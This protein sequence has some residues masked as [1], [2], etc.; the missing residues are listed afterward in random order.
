[1]KK[2][3]LITSLSVIGVLASTAPI[4]INC[5]LTTKDVNTKVTYSDTITGLELP[6]KLFVESKYT[7]QMWAKT[8]TGMVIPNVKFKIEEETTASLNATISGNTVTFSPTM[9]TKG[10]KCTLEIGA[11]QN[12]IK[13][14]NST[15]TFSEV[16]YANNLL[17]LNGVEY[18]LADNINPNK[19]VTLNWA[20]NWISEFIPLKDGGTLYIDAG[21]GKSGYLWQKL[22]SLTLRSC[23]PRVGVIEDCF[24]AKCDALKEVKLLDGLSS[25]ITIED[26]FIE[27]AHNLETVDLSGFIDLD[28]IGGC[29]IDEARNL[30]YVRMPN[31]CAKDFKVDWNYSTEIPQTAIVDCGN[32]LASYQVTYPWSRWSGQMSGSEHNY[33]IKELKWSPYSNP[34]VNRTVTADLVLLDDNMTPL[35]PLAETW[36]IEPETDECLNA[37]YDYPGIVS[38]TPTEEAICRTTTLKVAVYNL[39]KKIAELT[40]KINVVNLT[41]TITYNGRTYDIAYAIKQDL[42]ITYTQEAWCKYVDQQIPLEF[43]DAVLNVGG[44]RSAWGNLTSLS[45]RSINPANTILKYYFL[46]SCVNLKTLDLSGLTHL[47]YIG[48]YFLYKCINLTS[49]ILPNMSPR[50]INVAYDYFLADVPSTTQFHCGQ[51]V[52]EYKHTLPWSTRASQ[53]VE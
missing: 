43:V 13:I 44:S 37:V 8:S 25:I 27:K 2:I 38:I 30:N 4:T 47:T 6:N 10:K 33:S 41:N 48:G 3:K 19:F 26:G 5:C 14:A 32:H 40:T 53:M 17:T 39:D 35:H 16:A 11:Y 52:E 21:Y 49:V 12:G 42:F 18:E 36:R 51:Y 24:L 23:D 34:I 7:S 1:M 9:E 46:D 15:T 45:L 50:S 28:R 20:G 29:F 31:Q 22:T